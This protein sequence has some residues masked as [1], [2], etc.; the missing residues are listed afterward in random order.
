MVKL[1]SF[2]IGMFNLSLREEEGEKLC[3]ENGGNFSRSRIFLLQHLYKTSPFKY[4]T[5][6]YRKS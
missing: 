1:C 6:L 5:L 3:F 2:P 4:K